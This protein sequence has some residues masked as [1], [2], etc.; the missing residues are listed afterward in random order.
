MF[1]LFS[2]VSVPASCDNLAV[3][4]RLC[5][6]H[7]LVHMRT[8]PPGPKTP[9]YQIADRALRPKG[10][11]A[12]LTWFRKLCF[13]AGLT[14][15]FILGT[16]HLVDLA[17]RLHVREV[18]RQLPTMPESQAFHTIAELEELGPAGITAV[19]RGL[20]HPKSDVAEFAARVLWEKVFAARTS[21]QAIAEA[22]AAVAGI[23]GLWPEIPV[24]RRPRLARILR[25]YLEGLSAHST[26]SVQL[27]AQCATL[28]RELPPHSQ[29]VQESVAESPAPLSHVSQ[30]K[31]AEVQKP[32]ANPLRAP[33]L[34]PRSAPAVAGIEKPS[35]AAKDSPDELRLAQ[36]EAEE[37]VAAGF[38]ATRPGGTPVGRA[39]HTGS[40][41]ERLAEDTSLSFGPGQMPPTLRIPEHAEP[42]SAS[43]GLPRPQ[44]PRDVEEPVP[45]GTGNSPS[46]LELPEASSHQNTRDGI[47][48]GTSQAVFL[49]T[50]PW[51]RDR[52][53][54]S[55]FAAGG[56]EAPKARERLRE[57]GWI[58]EA[59]LV[60]RL[61]FH[62][63]PDERRK[64]VAAIW[65]T[66]GLD[67]L[68]LLMVLACDP[69]HTV[70]LEALS[71]LGTMSTPEALSLIHTLATQ[72]PD[73]QVRTLANEILAKLR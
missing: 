30:D 61:A 21:P 22:D 5:N 23:V 68:P 32:T 49:Q 43:Q 19:A 25:D 39:S 47:A 20:L 63:N 16:P 28:L 9:E 36:Y 12:T 44:V 41:S 66:A 18:G 14:G 37:G 73:L 71:A 60:G 45:N 15:L 55:Q 58:P 10:F 29:S 62:P 26:S 40:I 59:F 8:N 54:W 56:S 1:F 64:A 51:Q 7:V 33:G 31:A 67:P 34:S 57:H 24:N 65:N 50:N 52:A 53:L 70:R 13:L 11:R 69:D 27:A 4:F 42:L 6:P 48:E 35:A 38:S 46:A 3:D 17:V 2:L 72:D